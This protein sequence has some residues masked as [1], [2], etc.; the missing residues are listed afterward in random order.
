[1]LYFILNP[2][3]EG[4]I[5]PERANN[6]QSPGIK[7]SC[8]IF[9]VNRMAVHTP[10]VHMHRFKIVRNYSNLFEIVPNCLKG[11]KSFGVVR[12]HSDTPKP[13]VS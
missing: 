10:N 3:S 4:A 12:N 1:M 7:K 11:P 13:G 9:S 8:L 2:A 5:A 6:Y